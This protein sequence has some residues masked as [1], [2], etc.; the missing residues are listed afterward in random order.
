M[1][2]QPGILADVS[3]LARYLF[4]SLHT[5]VDL[6]KT[7]Q[8]LG[9]SVDGGQTVV[10]LGE[11]LVMALGITIDRLKTFPSY[12]GKGVEV[13]ST[14]GSLWCWLKGQDRGEL[15]HRT[16]AMEALLASTFR[17]DRT[18]EAF[19]Y[20][21]GRDLTGYEDGTENPTGKQA[22]D[23]AIF[24]NGVDGM[25]GSSFVAVQ[26]WIHDFGQFDSMSQREQDGTI[27]R[28]KSDNEELESAPESAHVKRTAQ[29]SFAPE[30]F[31]VR[32]SM[33]WTNEQESGLVFVA[34]GNSFDPFEA[35]MQRMVGLEDGISD[36]LFKFTRP[37]TG[38]YF[39]CPPVSEGS[40]DLSYLNL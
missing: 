7:L 8:T 9:A 6:P 15:L 23:V 33:P 20:D 13:P 12:T 38:N 3:P 29:E 22:E 35:L 40:L 39:W 36:A 32:R 24:Q 1:K 2:H 5:E 34:F 4:F 17:L 28:R 19:Q 31:I 37:I 30:A 21:S 26:Q 11:S 16:R 18:I 10:G 25:T 27:G 14:P